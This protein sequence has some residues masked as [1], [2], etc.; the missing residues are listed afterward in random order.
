MQI[1]GNVGHTTVEVDAGN[2]DA[3]N[4]DAVSC[5]PGGSVMR[6]NGGGRL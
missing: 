6:G 4:V 3:G 1:R 2:V 5:T